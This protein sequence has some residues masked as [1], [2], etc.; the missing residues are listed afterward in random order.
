MKEFIKVV[1]IM[2]PRCRRAKEDL[3]TAEQDL[4]ELLHLLEEGEVRNKRIIE[5]VILGIYT[6]LKFKHTD[7]SIKHVKK[8]LGILEANEHL[9]H[10]DILRAYNLINL[11]MIEMGQHR[12][13]IHNLEKEVLQHQHIIDTLAHNISIRLAYTHTVEMLT[14]KSGMFQNT[15]LTYQ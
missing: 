13:V 7:K 4:C 5:T 6:H 12:H 8:N 11:T 10:Q 15:L 2:T 14:A 9:N 3:S 1:G